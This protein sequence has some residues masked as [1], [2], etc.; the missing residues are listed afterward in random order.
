MR[1]HKYTTS[2]Y[3]NFKWFIKR[4]FLRKSTTDKLISEFIKNQ[5]KQNS[6]ILNI[7]A[8][9]W[10]PFDTLIRKKSK[11]VYNVDV[12]LFVKIFRLFDCK[13]LV[14]NDKNIYELISH[15]DVDTIVSFHSICYIHIDLPKLIRF[16]SENNITFLFDWNI[17]TD[18]INEGNISKFCCGESKFEILKLVKTHNLIIEDMYL[19]NR[20]KY[21]EQIYEGGRYF[22]LTMVK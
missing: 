7:G 9:Y 17:P 2:E 4:F 11:K 18:E 16:C 15:Y 1:F 12:S 6:T 21:K 13:R 19:K 5:I 3:L 8:G 14:I 10:A 20:V 22:V